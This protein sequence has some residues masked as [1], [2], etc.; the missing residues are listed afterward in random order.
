MG[1][2]G[3]SGCITLMI[4]CGLAGCSRGAEQPAKVPERVRLNVTAP[5]DG[6]VVR[7]ESVLVSGTV[8]PPG[9]VMVIDGREIDTS[10]G[11]FSTEVP[12]DVGGNVIDVLASAGRRR[13]GV[14]ALRVTRQIA[15]RVPSLAGVSADEARDRL[16][17]LGLRPEIT[18]RGTLL[19]DL[20]PIDAVVC[21][22][23]PAVGTEVQG[24]ATIRVE[25]RKLC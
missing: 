11:T 8:R 5:R 23:D 17:A 16:A 19:E 10:R 21:N 3:L 20:L 4:A 1:S 7:D 15:V 22:V 14:V 13:P 6:A 18:D 2:I 9:A 24:G 25:V 12:L